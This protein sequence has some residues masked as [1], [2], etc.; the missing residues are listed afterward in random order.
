MISL[1]EDHALQRRFGELCLI[2]FE[3]NVAAHRLY[4]RIGYK[5]V[6]REPAVPHPLIHF[7]GDAILIVRH[8]P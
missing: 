5:E 4:Q 1:A 3:Q 7:T 8:L 6:A 2:V